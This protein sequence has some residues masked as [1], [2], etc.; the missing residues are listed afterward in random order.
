MPAIASVFIATSLDGFIAR[1]DGSIDWLMAA[2]ASAPAGEDFGYQAFIDTVDALVMGRVTFE[3][4][5]SFGEWPYGQKPV[6]VLTR[7]GIS[8]PA[9]LQETVQ[10]TSESPQALIK[11]LESQGLNHLYVDGGQVIQSFL[12][13]GL[14]Q[15]LTIT[16]IPVLIGSGKPLFANLPHDIKLEHVATTSYPC[17]FVQSRYRTVLN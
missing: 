10:A 4:A 11:R 7:K 3:T 2:Q 8:I 12:A 5:L 16:T 17:G 15:Q 9:S 13:A 1:A 6:Y 14:I